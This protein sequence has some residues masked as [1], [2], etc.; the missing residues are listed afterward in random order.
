MAT[1]NLHA[2][3]LT[4]EEFLEI[5]FPPDTKAE[6][7][8]G[9]IRMMAGGT[10]KHA[11]VQANIMRYMGNALRGSGCKPFGSDLGVKTSDIALRYPDVTVL[12]GDRSTDS[13]AKAIDD[14]RLIVEVLSPGTRAL[15][16]GVKLA[17]YRAIPTVMTVLLV[18]PTTETVRLIERTG[19][20]I[21]MDQ[22]FASGTDV[23]LADLGITLPHGEIFA[24][25]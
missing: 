23:P 16:L 1:R 2:P 17:E 11:E 9:V 19:P 24:R 4:V 8:N 14:P 25:D 20:A 3:L 6:L 18:D 21:W 22:D 5:E 13:E 7:D 12:C 15:D 10:V